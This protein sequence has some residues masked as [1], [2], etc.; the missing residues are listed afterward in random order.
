[1]SE[2]PPIALLRALVRPY[3]ARLLKKPSRAG[4]LRGMHYEAK[5]GKW[6]SNKGAI[7]YTYSSVS[8]NNGG[9][10]DA[11]FFYWWGSPR[12]ESNYSMCR[13]CRVVTFGPRE[14]EMHLNAAVHQ[15]RRFIYNAFEVLR[16]DKKCAVCDKVSDRIRLGVYLCNLTCEDLW[17]T[18]PSKSD[19]ALKEALRIVGWKEEASL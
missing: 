6:V 4:S 13:V 18:E 11:D 17:K 1:L 15:C 14:R 16:R 12:K 2:Q 19:V 3:G 8:G 10:T 5:S 7:E 9:M